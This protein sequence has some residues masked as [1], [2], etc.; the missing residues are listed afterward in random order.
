[1]NWLLLLTVLS[2]YSGSSTTAVLVD[3]KE[4]CETVGKSHEEALHK[5]Q[6]Q[7]FRVI[8]SCNQIK[9]DQP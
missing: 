8:W 7:S 6:W 4:T 1:M 3:S 2:G 5:L 9:A